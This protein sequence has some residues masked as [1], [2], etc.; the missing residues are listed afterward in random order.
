[1]NYEIIVVGGGPAGLSAAKKAAQ[2]GY[3]VAVFEKS[4]E[5]GY[6]VHTSGVSWVDEMDRLGAPRMFMHF[7]TSVDVIT[8]KS[9]ATFEFKTPL[10]CVLDV[11]SYYQ[12]LAEQAAVAGAEIHVDAAVTDP[13]VNNDFV[14]GVSVRVHGK[15][16]RACSKVVIDAS[17]FAA[18][19]ARKMGLTS[20]WKVY[21]IGAEY[22]IHTPSWNQEKVC[23]ILSNKIAPGGYGWFFPCG[24]HRVRVGIGVARPISKADPVE[25]LDSFFSDEANQ[26]ANML[27]PYSKVEFH[28]GFGPCDGVLSK[29]IHNGLV[30]VGDA[31]GQMSALG[32]EGI[33]FAVDI[34]GMA[35][36]VAARA[37]SIG[38]YDE[39]A[40]IDYERKWRKKY[41]R[42]FKIAYE[43]NKYRRNYT[44]EE[45][46]E[47]V[48]KLSKLT[49]DS[50]VKFLKG[51]YTL[52]SFFEVLRQQPRMSYQLLSKIVKQKLRTK[53]NVKKS[54]GDK[55][56]KKDKR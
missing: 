52:T 2:S 55:K 54:K 20:K 4:K 40:L 42:K 53:D 43:I 47:K 31:A 9:K 49:P 1:M 50:L 7:V 21:G 18:L 39:G 6:P 16:Y 3:R 45:W 14:K 32:G 34:G 8:N 41:G 38:R 46:D 28:H 35:G 48:R 10:I 13:I 25:L 12:Y 36:T 30:V 33:R 37:I 56:K 15:Q 27:R 22:E 51:D 19:L 44:D 26:L 5:I 24:N 11:R 23:I 29:T 17:G